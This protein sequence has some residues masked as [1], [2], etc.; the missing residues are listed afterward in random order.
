MRHIPSVSNGSIIAALKNAASL[1][2]AATWLA[3]ANSAIAQAAPP[4]TPLDA[5]VYDSET[6]EYTPKP[7]ES[8]APFKFWV[9]NTYSSDAV[10]LSVTP[11][12]GCTSAKTPPMP[13]TLKPGESGSFEA[14]MD[15]ASK[16]GDV[17]KSIMVVSSSGVKGLTITV[18]M[19]G[20][21]TAA[22]GPMGDVDRTKNMQMAL[23]DRQVVFKGDCAACHAKPGEGKTGHQLYIAVCSNCH[24]SA[25]RAAMVPDLKALKHPTSAE[26]WRKWIT[27]GR[28][29]S[30]MPAFSQ[31]E[32]GPLTEAQVESLVTHLVATIPAQP[33]PAATA[34]APAPK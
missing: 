21:G 4:V 27:S 13:W 3:G 9:T 19:P 29:G 31:K 10:I 32:G 16:I 23:G 1:A 28:V 30:M 26:H 18:H 11:S 17:S 7:G 12:C 2:L 22:G 25:H 8:S 14:A 6:K 24:D 33:Q 20:A 5:L 34:P 15:L